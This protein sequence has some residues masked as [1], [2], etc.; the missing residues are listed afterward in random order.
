MVVRGFEVGLSQGAEGNPCG[1]IGEEKMLLPVILENRANNL[2]GDGG[3][4][5][6]KVGELTDR[7]GKEGGEAEQVDDVPE[8]GD[9]LGL[10]ADVRGAGW[11]Y[12]I[13]VAVVE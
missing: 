12:A 11:A 6:E 2:K 1:V 3:V 13:L 10:V 7:G 8:D 9:G 4:E 5:D